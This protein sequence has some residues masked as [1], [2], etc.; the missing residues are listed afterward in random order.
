M[1]NTAVMAYIPRKSII[2][3]LTGTT[4]FLVFLMFSVAGMMTFD[5]RVLL[6][7]LVFSLVAFKIGKI[8]LSEVK[9]MI[10]FMLVFL[11]LNSLF[12]YIFAPEQGVE[13]YGSRTI[14]FEGFGRY[15]ITQEQ[16]FYMF[17]VCL[18]YFVSL[19][20]AI[21]F[22]SATNPSEFASSLN[23]LGVPYRISYAVSLALRYIPDIQREFREINQAQQSRGVKLGKDTP[24]IQRLQNSVGILFPLILSSLDRIE[25]ISS[26]MELRG[27]GKNNKRTWYMQRSLKINDYIGI[28]M[29]VLILCTSIFVTYQN[30]SRFFNPFI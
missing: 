19:P 4:K 5:T 13:I 1:A 6:G 7:M 12:I 27:F 15:T 2:H 28:L 24:I 21:L 10:W 22:I 30:G 18:K 26:A 3:D 25:V 9:V 14:I 16:L 17:N 8:K 11:F 23:G 20:M 29:G